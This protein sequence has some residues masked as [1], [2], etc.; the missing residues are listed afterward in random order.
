MPNPVSNACFRRPALPHCY[1]M[2]LAA[3]R[4]SMHL[5]GIAGCSIR[6]RHH[7]VRRAAARWTWPWSAVY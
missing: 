1:L 2:V 6:T 3:R 5:G 7:I 4:Q